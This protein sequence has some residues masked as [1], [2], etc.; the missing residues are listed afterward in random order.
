M[1]EPLPTV[2]IG[3]ALDDVV[4]RLEASGAVLVL[5]GGRPTGLITRSDVLELMADGGGPSPDAVTA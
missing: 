4:H 1:D 3:E 2:G 5:D